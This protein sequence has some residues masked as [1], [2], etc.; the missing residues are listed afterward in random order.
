MVDPGGGRRGVRRAAVAAGGTT[1]PRRWRHR[2]R[3]EECRRRLSAGRTCLLRLPQ[4]RLRRSSWA[5]LLPRRVDLPGRPGLHLRHHCIDAGPDFNP[6]DSC[7]SRQD[8]S[9]VACVSACSNDAV[10]R[11]RL[12]GRRLGLPAGDVRRQHLPQSFWLGPPG[13]SSYADADAT[14]TIEPPWPARRSASASGAQNGSEASAYQA[15]PRA[16]PACPTR[17][18]ARGSE[19]RRPSSRDRSRTPISTRVKAGLARRRAS[20]SAG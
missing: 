11:A 10:R 7:L 14:M 16:R 4:L 9:I 15:V 2:P 5:H 17:G 3:G 8:G 1:V 20:R 13:A 18:R 12:L 6:G 19:T